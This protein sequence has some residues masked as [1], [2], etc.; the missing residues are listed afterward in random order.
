MDVTNLAGGELFWTSEVD[1]NTGLPVR[2]LVMKYGA[3]AFSEYRHTLTAID[4]FFT[5]YILT[6]TSTTNP[7]TLA[8]LLFGINVLVIPEQEQGNPAVWATLAP[9]IQNYL[10]N[11]GSVIWCGSY[12]SQADCIFSGGV[13]TGA[14]ANDAAQNQLTVVDPTHPLA[15]GIANGFT[16]PSATYTCSLTNANKNLIIA[17]QNDDVV[18]WVPYGSGKAIF[19]AFDF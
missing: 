11:G 19:L 14:F 13:F 18:T 12:S 1:V 5:N 2:V 4:T 9:V 3:D 16:A 15:A 8:S 6:T 10:N 17:D 7:G